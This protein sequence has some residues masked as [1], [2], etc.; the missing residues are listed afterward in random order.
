MPL[1]T[2]DAERVVAWLRTVRFCDGLDSEQLAAIAS[3]CRVRPF[4]AGETLASAGDEVTEF[5]ILVE[6]ELDS[7]LTDPRGRE[8]WLATIRQ[9]E[10]VGEI[11]ILEK[12]PTRPVRFTART[13][14]TLLVAPAAFLHEWVKTYP[15]MMQN[16][17]H[18]LSERFKARGRCGGAKPA[19]AAARNRR[20]VAAWLCAGW[21]PG[22]ALARGRRTIAS[23]G[24][25]AVE[26]DVDGELAR[27][28]AYSRTR[29]KRYSAV[30][31]TCA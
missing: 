13:H 24:R 31:A 4:V 23:L 19:V 2:A 7:F 18:T 20:H 17:F 27:R 28:L 6:G 1:L 11:A 12:A 15:Q 25:P 26:L 10:T 29:G 9:G 21:T 8:K 16:L 5:W 30:A 14:G 3:E 22:S